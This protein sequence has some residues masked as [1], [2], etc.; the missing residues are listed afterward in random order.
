MCD[1]VSVYVYH[2]VMENAI[3]YLCILLALF[4]VKPEDFKA[5]RF[6]FDLEFNSNKE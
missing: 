6:S 1:V 3:T 5:T 2:S 4:R